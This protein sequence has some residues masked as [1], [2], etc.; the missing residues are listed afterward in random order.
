[1]SL[2]LSIEATAE[3]GVSAVVALAGKPTRTPITAPKT[4]SEN[5]Q[6]CLVQSKPKVWVVARVKF[7][8]T[9]NVLYLLT[10]KIPPSPPP[11]F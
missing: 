4:W 3:D 1:M 10:A 9:L 11:P 6:D 7:P 2:D 5:V 8:M